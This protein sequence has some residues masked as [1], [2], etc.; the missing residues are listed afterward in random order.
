MSSLMFLWN[1]KCRRL[2]V[3]V[4]LC[5]PNYVRKQ[6]LQTYPVAASQRLKCFASAAHGFYAH[7][8]FTPRHG[9]CLQMHYV[10]PLLLKAPMHML[11]IYAENMHSSPQMYYVATS[12]ETK[13]LESLSRSPVS[14]AHH[15]RGAAPQ[16]G[17]IVVC[18]QQTA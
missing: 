18:A 12:R 11:N 17:K 10:A 7:A 15:G 16:A 13:R 3:D 14:S 5:L 2:L 4:C 1:G 9:V 6:C 8:A